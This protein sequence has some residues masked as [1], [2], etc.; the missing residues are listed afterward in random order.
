[1]NKG[2]W[3]GLYDDLAPS[4]R[5]LLTRDAFA[6]RMKVGLADTYGASVTVIEMSILA[7]QGP[8]CPAR[9]C[10]TKG[11]YRGP[12]WLVFVYTDRWVVWETG[13]FNALAGPK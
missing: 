4:F 7:V 12:S 11:T 10:G 8:T 9:I 1:M 2:D 13:D 6:C 3:A 5:N